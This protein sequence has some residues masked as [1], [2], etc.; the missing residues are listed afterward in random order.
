M[1]QRTHSGQK[2]SEQRRGSLLVAMLLLAGSAAACHPPF[3]YRYEN[4][5]GVGLTDR[6]ADYCQRAAK[7]VG[8]TVRTANPKLVESPTQVD[9][10]MRVVD[11]RGELIAACEFDDKQRVV[12]LPK[13]Q[14]GDVRKGVLGYIEGDAK[15]AK[16]VCDRAV[17][18]SGYDAREIS[19]AEWTGDR[20]YRVNVA[21]RQGG[22]DRNVACRY[23]G[24]PGTASVPP[25]TK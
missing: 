5:T 21:V 19:V 18:S 20:R 16:S 9:I 7:N 4:A 14:R 13:P 6:A 10:R 1:M 11:N 17:K 8:Y 15:Q 2:H 22:A 3:K 25:V 12:A 23:D 24:V